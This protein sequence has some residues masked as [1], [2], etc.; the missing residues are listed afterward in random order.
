M[1]ITWPKLSFILDDTAV[2]YVDY[3]NTRY[4][5]GFLAGVLLLVV[6]IVTM[7]EA[8]RGDHDSNH[9]S[10]HDSG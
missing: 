1:K 6:A 8:H 3:G 7:I 9:D 10:N 4:R 5:L 2:E